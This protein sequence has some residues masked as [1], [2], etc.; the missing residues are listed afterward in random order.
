MQERKTSGKYKVYHRNILKISNFS[1]IGSC[2]VILVTWWLANLTG[3]L[4]TSSPPLQEEGEKSFFK[5]IDFLKPC[6]R[7]EV[8]YNI[9]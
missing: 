9:N 7:G 4:P 2:S 3:I 6:S 5:K 1:G 8:G